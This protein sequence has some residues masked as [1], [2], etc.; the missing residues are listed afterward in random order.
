MWTAIHGAKTVDRELFGVLSP[1]E[2]AVLRP[3]YS[4]I[5][6]YSKEAS[7]HVHDS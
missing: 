4:A 1:E 7:G 6:S 2:R 5:C 3:S